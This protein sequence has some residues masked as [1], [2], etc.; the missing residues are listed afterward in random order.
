MND[1]LNESALGEMA[2]AGGEKIIDFG[3]ATG[4]MSLAMA[5]AA[6]PG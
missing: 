6:G 3:S 1:L 5:R 4:R 2:L